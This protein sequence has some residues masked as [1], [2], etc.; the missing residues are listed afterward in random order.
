MEIGLFYS[1]KNS[2]HRKAASFVKKAVR[3]LG[4]NATITEMDSQI[5]LPRL[6]VDGYDLSALLA[7]AG[8]NAASQISYDQIEKALESTAW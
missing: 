7:F 2:E 5:P 6:L 3:N 8:E 1:R 4:L